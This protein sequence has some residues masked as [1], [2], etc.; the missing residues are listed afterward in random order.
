LLDVLKLS[1]V[2]GPESGSTTLLLW[3]PKRDE[4][5]GSPGG[6]M[7]EEGM[8][9]W[10]AI[11]GMELSRSTVE[12]ERLR[13]QEGPAEIKDERLPEGWA[14]RDDSEWKIGEMLEVVLLAADGATEEE[15]AG[16][17]EEG[18]PMPDLK[19]GIE[20]MLGE[21]RRGEPEPLGGVKDMVVGIGFNIGE[22]GTVI[23]ELVLPWVGVAGVVVGVIV[24]PFP[25]P[26]TSRCE[27]MMRLR[28]ASAASGLM[29]PESRLAGSLKSTCAKIDASLSIPMG[30]SS[31]TICKK[32]ARYC[33]EIL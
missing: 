10:L 12:G 32:F 26:K 3:L 2:G 30:F 6:G 25:F 7:A 8:T 22:T 17:L 23:L 18:R 1:Y 20:S 19:A 28:T 14:A 15:V 11:M 27:I 29:P 4:F 16:E 31:L 21:F 13:D 24:E 9:A 5:L 33:N